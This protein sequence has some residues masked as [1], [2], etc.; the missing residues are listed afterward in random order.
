M[1]VPGVP[2]RAL[3][4]WAASCG[5][6][7]AAGSVAVTQRRRGCQC[8]MTGSTH[9]R[10]GRCLNMA[11][12]FYVDE[13]KSGDYLLGVVVVPVEA[14]HAANRAVKDFLLPAQRSLHTRKET[15]GRKRQALQVLKGLSR[16]HDVEVLIV[17]SGRA[18]SQVERRARAIT[19]L[20]PE[21]NDGD[22]VLFDRDETL[23]A[24][25]KRSMLDLTRARGVEVT[26]RHAEP[27]QEL[28]LGLA[29][30]VAWAAGASGEPWGSLLRS[31][32]VRTVGS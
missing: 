30:V 8:R 6:T 32:A 12:I 7:E 26:Y 19:L 5:W 27:S 9:D 15:D 11:R 20:S 23:E 13:R 29:D 14:R 3:N 28:A 16:A 31:V 17:N 2:T 4:V 22:T 1:V 18:G 25:D 21:W 24:R 10:C